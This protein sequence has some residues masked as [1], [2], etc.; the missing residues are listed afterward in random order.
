MVPLGPDRLDLH[1]L[2]RL[3]GSNDYRPRREVEGH[4]EHVCVLDIEQAII[5]KVVGLSAQCASNNL[6][7]EGVGSRRLAHRE[8]A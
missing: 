1:S 5:V 4:T 6:L 7:A 2:A 8:R 3:L